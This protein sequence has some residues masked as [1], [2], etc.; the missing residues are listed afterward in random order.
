MLIGNFISN[1]YTAKCSTSYIDLCF[2]SGKFIIPPKS[3]NV[4]K[5]GAMV[6]SS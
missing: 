5:A 2:V 1:E 6:F 4:F 3:E